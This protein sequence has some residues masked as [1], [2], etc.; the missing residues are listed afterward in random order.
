M[1]SNAILSKVIIPE[2]YYP[3]NWPAHVQVGMVVGGIVGAAGSIGG[4]V[5]ERNRVKAEQK[6][7]EVEAK[8]LEALI[9]IHEAVSKKGTL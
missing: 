2:K 4:L 1:K 3:K 5:S 6:R 7:L 9:K 8:S